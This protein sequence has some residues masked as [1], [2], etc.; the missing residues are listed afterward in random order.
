M[1]GTLY[2]SVGKL[3]SS[4]RAEKARIKWATKMSVFGVSL[5]SLPLDLERI[6]TKSVITC[7]CS[8][9]HGEVSDGFASFHRHSLNTSHDQDIS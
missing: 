6:Y 8:R 7:T 5:N 3:L 4:R 2:E 1:G 9:L